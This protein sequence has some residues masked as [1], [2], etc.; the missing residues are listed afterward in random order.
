MASKSNK[1][2]KSDYYPQNDTIVAIA[3]APGRAG[4]AIVK[5]SGPDSISILNSLFKGKKNPEFYPRRMIHGIINDLSQKVDEALVCFMKAP[6]SYTGEDVIEIQSHG[7]YASGSAIL[8]LVIGKGARPAEP[9]EFTKRA[10]LNGRIDLTQAEAVMEIVA[11]EGIEHLRRAEKLMEGAFSKRIETLIHELIHSASLT[12]LN[13]DFLEQG[14]EAIPVMELKNSIEKT[15]ETL[16]TMLESYTAAQRIKNGLRVAITGKVNSGKSSLFNALLG[17]KRAIVNE[18]PGTTR[19][20]IEEKIE[21]FGL[22]INLIDTAGLRETED[23]I[24]REG[25]DEA[26]RFLR[27]ADIVI[28][29]NEHGDVHRIVENVSIESPKIIPVVSKADLLDK[30]KKNNEILSVSSLTGEGIESLIAEIVT[31]ARPLINT[32]D[33]DSLVMVE[34]HRLLLS[35]AREHLIEALQSLDTW[36]EEITALELRE[37]QSSLEEILGKNISIDVLDDIFKHFCIGK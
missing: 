34:R 36:S 35:G 18:R 10:F 30:R 27:D 20:W 15:V 19:D 5:I 22:P 12:E 4:I 6:H 17:R 7:G 3:T 9:G 2:G 24:E 31:Y 14:L 21:L 11:A 16:D 37:A 23:D 33:I 1:R 25:V 8:A 13:I 28:S 32:G 26:K 29:L